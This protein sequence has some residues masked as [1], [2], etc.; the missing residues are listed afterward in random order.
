MIVPLLLE[1]EIY[2]QTSG[3]LI[4]GPNSEPESLLHARKHFDDLP[5]GITCTSTRADARN[6]M[7]ERVQ[8]L[9]LTRPILKKHKLDDIR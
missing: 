1:D 7:K 2:V 4:Y 6:K 3:G 8:E 5:E 9:G